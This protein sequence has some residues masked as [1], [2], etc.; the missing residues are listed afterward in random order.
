MMLFKIAAIAAIVTL[1]LLAVARRA[2][3]E[4]R[5]RSAIALNKTIRK[6]QN[7]KHKVALDPDE[8]QRVREHFNAD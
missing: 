3:L 4:E 1:V 8:R 6:A 5:A 7:V 2:R